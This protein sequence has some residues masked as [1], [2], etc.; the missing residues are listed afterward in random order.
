MYINVYHFDGEGSLVVDEYD[1]L[2]NPSFAPE[3]D[4]WGTS[5]PANEFTMDVVTADVIEIGYYVELFDDLDNLYAFYWIFKAEKVEATITRITARTVIGLLD[6]VKMPAVMYANENAEDAIEACFDASDSGFTS[7]LSFD[8]SFDNVTISGFCPEQTARERVTWILFAIGGYARTA[9]CDEIEI[10]PIDST[11]T[12]IPIDRTFWKPTVTYSDWVTAIRAKYYS[13][14][15]GTPATTDEY[16]TDGEGTT[17]I[18]TA[19][20]VSLANPDAPGAAPANV[21]DISDVMLLNS[22]NISAVLSRLSQRYFKPITLEADVIDNA[23]YVPG[24]KVIVYA[25]ENTLYGGYIES[26]DFSFGVQARARLK[27][28]ACD[29]REAAPLTITCLYGDTVI[30]QSAY[31]F[32]VG[33]AYSVQTHYIDWTMN[34]HRYIFRPTTA[35]VTGTMTAQGATV[36]VEYAVALDLY[37]GVLRVVSVDGISTTTESGET[38]GVIE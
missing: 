29:A 22:A 1:T 4:L 21:V 32:P 36:E 14:V 27:L 9:F 33:Y 34:G 28:A 7:G 11:E 16:V 23:E 35:A 37:E 18:V 24:D 13:F 26:A 8:S 30:G 10:L 2:R 38:V 3:V 19:T 15:Q 12:L 20:E 6:N 17:Y 5:L 31:T 25:D